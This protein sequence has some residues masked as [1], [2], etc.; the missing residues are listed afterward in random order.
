M[1][2]WRL[3]RSGH[4]SGATNM[5]LDLALATL[6]RPGDPPIL[7]CYGWQPAC[8]SLGK[9]QAPEVV[10]REA[11]RRLGLEVCRR[12]TGGGAILHEPDE[13][14]FSIIIGLQAL[15]ARGVMESYRILSAAIVAGLR[16]LGVR[17]RLVDNEGEPQAGPGANPVCF[18]RR[19]RCDISCRGHKLV[20]SAQMHRRGVVLQQSALPVSTSMERMAAVFGPQAAEAEG[21]LTLPQAAGRE[22]PPE[23]VWQALADGVAR[24]LGATMLAAKP[25]PAELEL[26][27]RLAADLRII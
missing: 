16:L 14:T 20:G 6:H 8:V 9:H 13:I 22:V 11:C 17:A 5:A 15:G 18:A 21:L 25:E 1:T 4:Q 12:P 3:I 19:A 23:Q 27:G 26:A 2:A 10:N 24:T 7:H